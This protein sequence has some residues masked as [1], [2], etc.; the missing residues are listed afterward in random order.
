MNGPDRH[1]Q[2]RRPGS[3]CGSPCRN[4]AC[5]LW[6]TAGG[7]VFLTVFVYN[8]LGEAIRDAIDPRLKI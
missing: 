6:C 2:E 1:R 7:A 5:R 3:F 4:E 8:L